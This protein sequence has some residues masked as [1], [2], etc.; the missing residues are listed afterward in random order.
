MADK[1]FKSPKNNKINIPS[2]SDKLCT[3]V[4][5]VR[6]SL[7]STSR[8]LVMARSTLIDFFEKI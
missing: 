6:L 1:S 4:S 5:V 2:V 7:N 8:A 3:A